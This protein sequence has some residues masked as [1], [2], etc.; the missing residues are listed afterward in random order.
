MN[1]TG[2]KSTNEETQIV[3]NTVHNGKHITNRE[4]NIIETTETVKA[5]GRVITD[6]VYERNLP[7]A[8]WFD[9]NMF[10][11][12]DADVFLL[13]WFMLNFRSLYK[14]MTRY[15]ILLKAN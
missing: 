14:N 2:D 15:P 7:F 9:K 13:F 6:E 11:D 10:L 8:L 5:T 4:Q 3:T 12:A 1:S